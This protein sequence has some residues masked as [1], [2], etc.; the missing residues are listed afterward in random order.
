QDPQ[1]GSFGVYSAEEAAETYILPTL[2][3]LD[4]GS[5]VNVAEADDADAPVEYYNLQG[6]RVANPENGLFIRRQGNKVEKV[7]IR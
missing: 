4:T 2:Y 5:S 3:K 7:V 6:M 1:Y